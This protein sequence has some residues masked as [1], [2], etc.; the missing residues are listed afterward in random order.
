MSLYCTKKFTDLQVHVQS[1]LLYNCCKAWPE[2]ISLDWLENNPGKLFHTD[3]MIEDRRLM[4]EDK[5]CKSC[6][7]GCYKYEEQGLLSDRQLNKSNQFISDPNAQ[8]K[9]LQISLSTDCNLTCMYCGPEWSSSWHNDIHK[10]G[11]YKL[12]G[13]KLDKDNFSTLW[14]K[15]KQKSRT[16]ETKFFQLL[17]KEIKMANGLEQINVLGGEPLL[18]NNLT[19]LLQEVEDKSITIISGLGVNQKRL[20]DILGKINNKNI[21]FKVSGEATGKIFELIRYGV[22]WNSFLE[23]I[24]IITDHGYK[25]SFNSSISNLSILDFSNFYKFFNANHNISIN[26]ITNRWFL[27]PHVLDDKSKENFIAN[28]DIFTDRKMFED[29]K[30]SMNSSYTDLEYKNFIKFLKEFSSRRNID[31]S[32]LP[33]HFKKWCNL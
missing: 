7:F 27:M 12:D 2:R 19:S 3:T 23:N 14:S 26:A 20:K 1:R 24:K 13:F 8:L 6:H 10:K 30:N 22:D 11:S 16:S 29:I 18:H 31:L 5:S 21:E 28:K 32:F 15:L 33:E 25:V 17:L 9:E 4:L